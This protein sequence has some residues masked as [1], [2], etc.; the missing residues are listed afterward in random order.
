[1]AGDV[2]IKLKN[3]IKE[4]KT[5]YNEIANKS[6]LSRYTVINV[7]N[8]TSNKREYIDKI[9]I[10]TLSDIRKCTPVLFGF[11]R[12]GLN[13]EHLTM[14]SIPENP[15]KLELIEDGS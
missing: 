8:G 12:V 11:I 6:G 2:N 5:S 9:P 14:H 7:I 4:Q 15:M 1:M 10:S 13:D 3:A